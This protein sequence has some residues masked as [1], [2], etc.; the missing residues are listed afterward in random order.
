M[1][2]EVFLPALFHF[3]LA[4]NSYPLCC[5]LLTMNSPSW[6]RKVRQT[7]A[8][9]AGIS[10]QYVVILLLR[11]LLVLWPFDFSITLAGPLK[12]VVTECK[13]DTDVTVMH[14]MC[15]AFKYMQQRMRSCVLNTEGRHLAIL[16][17]RARSWINTSKNMQ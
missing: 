14:I 2:M 9:A 15:D 13:E 11:L 16:Y 1:R 6:L 17:E 5:Q 4:A 10:S 3:V 12:P 8:S 7:A